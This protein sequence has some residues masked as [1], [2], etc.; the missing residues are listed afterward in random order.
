MYVLVQPE[1]IHEDPDQPD[2]DGRERQQCW[3]IALS[4]D[5]ADGKN[6]TSCEDVHAQSLYL[7]SAAPNGSDGAQAHAYA[8]DAGDD[9]YSH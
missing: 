9:P 5:S 2:D 4:T 3:S 6:G 1:K 8:H 7:V